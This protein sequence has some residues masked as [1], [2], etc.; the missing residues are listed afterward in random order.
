MCA[1]VQSLSD[2]GNLAN[3]SAFLQTAVLFIVATTHVIELTRSAITGNAG[4]CSLLP[5]PDVKHRLMTSSDASFM[6]MTEVLPG[7][8]SLV[9]HERCKQ[10]EVSQIAE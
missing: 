6:T 8:R 1:A 4:E 9:A 2:Q 5:C 7:V 3:L 10:D